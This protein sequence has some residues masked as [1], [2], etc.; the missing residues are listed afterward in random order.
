M[1]L[2]GYTT[3]RRAPG[4]SERRAP[5]AERGRTAAAPVLP[6]AAVNGE[7]RSRGACVTADPDLFFPISSVGP[8]AIQIAKAK[9]VCATCQVQRE[10]LSFALETHQV[11]GIWGGMSAEE[12]LLLRRRSRRAA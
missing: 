11:H 3:E 8:A 2:N 6:R 9:A 1:T 10:C 4:S 7:W 5:E 12:R